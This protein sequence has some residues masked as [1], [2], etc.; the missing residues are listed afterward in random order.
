MGS[1]VDESWRIWG[2]LRRAE[3]ELARG[4]YSHGFG[5]HY[6]SMG[7]ALTASTNH[8]H[9]WHS[10][11]RSRVDRVRQAL[12]D[13]GPMAQRM[14]I[15]RLAGIGLEGIWEILISA[16]EDIALYYGGP[17]IVG[18]VAG[19]I[20]GTFFGGVGAIPGAS[21]GAAVGSYVGT[22]VLAMLGLKSLA[23]GV[24]QAVP[25]AVG[26]YQ[27]GFVEAW[28]P[29]R[30]D[31]HLGSCSGRGGSA[32]CAASHLANGHVIVISAILTGLMLYLTRGRGDKATLLKEIGQSPR[33]GPKVA[34][35]VEKNEERL[36]RYRPM[37]S[38]RAG[39]KPREQPVA[40]SRGGG[41]NKGSE[42]HRPK[43]MPAAKV[44]CFTTKG[45]P[46]KHV[47]EFDRQLL[48]QERGI[49]TVTVKEYLRGR[50]AFA[51]GTSTRDP[52]VA[53]KARA[54]HQL[55]LLDSKTE[56]LVRQ[57]WSP[58][59]AVEEAKKIAS[60]Q[61]KTLAAL[62][63]PDMVAGGKD[64]IDCF[65]NCNVNKRIGAQWNRHDRLAELDKAAKRV[66]ADMRANTRMN[67]K[68]ERCK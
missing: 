15:Q 58:A 18:G 3:S 11:H 37:Q 29:A 19:G 9:T 53:R 7:R 35:W 34:Q 6:D 12:K 16:C 64:V 28:G 66:G 57:G 32:F 61:M 21:G 56:E 17:V 20:G 26:Y 48:G 60:D 23:E 59:E 55:G 24:V 5:A 47:G 44:P 51:K 25:E 39:E 42:P 54:D 62:H 4:A 33:L 14:L 52:S 68:L 31:Q 27:Q 30:Q 67:A 22:A 13:S 63:N 1:V 38:T 10:A 41:S 45:L 49:N 50:A 43:G 36:R 8:L 2:D 46:A 40:T 65:G